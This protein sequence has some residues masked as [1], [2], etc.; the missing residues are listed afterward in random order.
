MNQSI[1]SWGTLMYYCLIF[2][3][4]VDSKHLKKITV[5]D[6]VDVMRN[7]IIISFLIIAFY[8]L[9]GGYDDIYLKYK[10]EINSEIVCEVV[11][12]ENITKN[13]NSP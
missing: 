4:S 2:S 7:L 1:Q 13:T 8:Y 10:N 12:L 5:S 11:D 6:R 9:N 3:V